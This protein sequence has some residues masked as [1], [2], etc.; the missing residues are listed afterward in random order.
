MSEVTDFDNITFD[1]TTKLTQINLL[2]TNYDDSNEGLENL[3]RL[4]LIVNTANNWRTYEEYSIASINFQLY[5]R[6][7][8]FQIT[9]INK[10]MLLKILNDMYK[11]LK[12]GIYDIDFMA[13]MKSTHKLV[14]LKRII[15]G[16]SINSFDFRI[17]FFLKTARPDR[18]IK[19]ALSRDYVRN[20]YFDKFKKRELRNFRSQLFPEE[21]ELEEEPIDIPTT[22]KKADERANYFS[23]ST[24]DS[25]E[26]DDWVDSHLQSTDYESQLDDKEFYDKFPKNYLGDGR[27][28]RHHLKR[29]YKHNKNKNTHYISCLLKLNKRL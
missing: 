22:S 5:F 17:I 27:K 18:T 10:G 19:D 8:F 9:D 1:A 23:P 2:F 20:N 29:L 16:D 7:T 12:Y 26:Y 28:I 11:A 6:D 13:N 3:R 25:D 15:L 14:S 4:I 24:E 21:Y